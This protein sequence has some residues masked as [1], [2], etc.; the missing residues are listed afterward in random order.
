MEMT[1][2]DLDLQRDMATVRSIADDVG[3]LRAL[4]LEL[5]ASGEFRRRGYFTPEEDDAARRLLLLYRNYRIAL[6]DVI[7]RCQT[8]D[9][10]TDP[11]ERRLTFLVGYGAAVLMY[12]WSAT[13][14]D[15]YRDEDMIRRKLNEPD[16]RYDI[17]ANLFERIHE[18]LTSTD[19]LRRLHD[20]GGYFAS[21]Q[22]TLIADV[23]GDPIARWLLDEVHRQRARIETSWTN[24]LTERVLREVRSWRW[25]ARDDLAEVSFRLKALL[26]DWV[27]NIWYDRHPRIPRYQLQRLQRL[28]Q[29]GDVIFVR[30]ERKS[31]TIFLPGWWTHAAYYHGG[32]TGLEAGG[33]HDL[34]PVKQHWPEVLQLIDGQAV[35]VVEALSAG[36]VQNPLSHTLGVDHTVIFRPRYGKAEH[37]TAMASVFANIGKEYDFEVD[38]TRTDR[39]VCTE[40]LYRAMNGLGNVHFDLVSR[41]GKPTLTADDMVRQI[42]AASDAGAPIMDLVAISVRDFQRNRSRLYTGPDAHDK[43]RATIAT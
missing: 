26:I 4:R 1:E 41:L 17:E 5:D 27:G 37:A 3:R 36:V 39:L 33:F 35:T 14:V 13:L 32:S 42:V 12:N 20:A 28:M 18:S 23:A 34:P 30:P 22:E 29:P 31:S 40:V 43:M 2:R 21:Q 15:A 9:Q 25:T 16:K 38:F 10:I 11:R 8:F 7:S 19:N 24:I 6:F